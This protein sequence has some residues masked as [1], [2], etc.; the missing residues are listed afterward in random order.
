MPF[1]KGKSGNPGGRA[2]VKLADGR[3]L[4][5]LAREHT[6]EALNVLVAV[7]RNKDEPGNTRAAAADKVLARGW[8]QAPQTIAFTDDRQPVDLSGMTNEQLEALETFRA[9]AD[10]KT[11]DK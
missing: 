1:K 11:G 9:L 10:I 2:K 4:G 6:E 5:D 8:G 7:M 3:T